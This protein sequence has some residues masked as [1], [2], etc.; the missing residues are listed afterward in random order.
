MSLFTKAAWFTEYMK[1]FSGVRDVRAF[2]GLRKGRMPAGH[3]MELH[4]RRPPGTA[5]TCRAGTSDAEVLWTCSGGST[6]C[7]PPICLVIR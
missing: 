1:F 3:E 2:S 5:L 7:P 6:I 4:L